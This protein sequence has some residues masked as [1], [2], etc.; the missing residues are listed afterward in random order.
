MPFNSLPF[1]LFFSLFFLLYWR[2]FNKSLV[3]QNLLILS[4]SYFFYIW[5]DWRFLFLLIAN[6]ALNYFLAIRIRRTD[7]ERLR[8]ILLSV[9]LLEGLGGYQL[10]Y[11][12]D[13]Q[14]FAGCP[15]KEDRAVNRLGSLF[16]LCGLFPVSDGRT[17]RPGRDVDAP[18]KYQAGF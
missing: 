1:I 7:D 3:L 17:D 9:G 6:S 8:S 13:Y 12:Q 4:G 18:I 11:L 5:W 14:L 2:L 15:A 16:L 10:L